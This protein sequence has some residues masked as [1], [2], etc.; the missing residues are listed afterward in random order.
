MRVAHEGPTSSHLMADIESASQSA[1][2]DNE[3]KLDVSSD[4]F[5][6]SKHFTADQ[7]VR[8]AATINITGHEHSSQDSD[9]IVESECSKKDKSLSE[10]DSS[11]EYEGSWIDKWRVW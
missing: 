5:E 8:A 2:S 6:D 3:R 7:D 9:S 4:E 1:Q 10:Y 11:L